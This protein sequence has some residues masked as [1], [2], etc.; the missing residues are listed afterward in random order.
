M[1]DLAFQC[2][3]SI[4]SGIAVNLFHEPAGERL[5]ASL[6]MIHFLFRLDHQVE[7]TGGAGRGDRWRQ[8][9]ASSMNHSSMNHNCHEPTARRWTMEI[10]ILEDREEEAPRFCIIF[11][12]N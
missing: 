12:D 1:P 10:E 3:F 2:H 7:A 6:P 8:V 11:G 9:V 5:Q 4:A